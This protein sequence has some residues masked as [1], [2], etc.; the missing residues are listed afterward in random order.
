M[1]SF[2]EDAE[3]ENDVSKKVISILDEQE[4][5]SFEKDQWNIVKQVSRTFSIPMKRL[6][7]PLR[8][9]VVHGYLICRF[10]DTLEDAPDM[11]F[12]EKQKSLDRVISV[13][14]G[15]VSPSEFEDYFSFI[16]NTYTMGNEGEKESLER[17]RELFEYHHSLP[18]A[19]Q[20]NLSSIAIEMAEGMKKYAFSVDKKWEGIESQQ[21]F[22]EYTY[23]VAGLVGVFLTQLFVHDYFEIPEENKHV[24]ESLS[25]HFG[26]A[27]QYVNILKDCSEDA[28]D[29]RFFLPQDLLEEQNLSADTF[30][31]IENRDRAIFVYKKL[32]EQAKSYLTDAVN[33]ISHIPVTEKTNPIR[34]FCILPTLMAIRNIRHIEDNISDTLENSSSGK[35]SRVFVDRLKINVSKAAHSHEIFMKEVHSAWE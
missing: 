27:L 22:E 31:D 20:E 6:N 26:K 17:S 7:P 3:S 21:D 11:P 33:Y 28:K 24:L 30:F 4:K 35:I 5:K 2:C 32:I 1:E 10:L 25:I 29:G 18:P 8:E 19:V 12:E 13:L 15:T 9:H 34:E 16:A 23:F 14:N